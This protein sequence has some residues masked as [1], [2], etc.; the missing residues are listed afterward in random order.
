MVICMGFWKWLGKKI[1]DVF[2][3]IWVETALKWMLPGMI[4]TFGY[5]FLIVYLNGSNHMESPYFELSFLALPVLLLSMGLP[6][7]YEIYKDENP[8][9]R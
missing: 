7:L 3:S 4:L 1:K 5:V 2:K 8:V 6:I 9:E